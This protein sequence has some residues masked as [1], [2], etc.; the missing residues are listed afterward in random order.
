MR[1]N[2]LSN[3][4]GAVTCRA[5]HY[6]KAVGHIIRAMG[7]KSKGKIVFFIYLIVIL[8]REIFMYLKYILK[9]PNI[10][11]AKFILFGQGKT[12]SS[13]LAD[14]LSSYPEIQ[15]DDEVLVPV[16]FFPNQS[17]KAGCALSK[18]NVYG[19]KILMYQLNL[20][21]GDQ[22]MQDAKQ[23][24]HELHQQGWK[25][26]YLKRGNIFRQAVDQLMLDFYLRN[27][28]FPF[29]KNSRSK[30]DRICLDCNEAIKKMKRAEL[31]S[32]QEAEVLASLPHLSIVFEDDLLRVENHQKTVD[33]IFAYLGLPAVPVKTIFVKT[34]AEWKSLTIQN[35]EELKQM[36]SQTE[37]A[38]FLED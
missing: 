34:F 14:L 25:I 8:F 4:I 22:N 31:Y 12:G 33:K 21:G 16:I 30:S 37:Y 38:K 20:L 28:R 13:L 18:K 9:K 29:W 32:A 15:Y 11:I 1:E 26:I 7:I 35:D 2:K 36:I 19:I 10:P 23:F 5:R 3:Y 6:F 17:V 27:Y 24:M